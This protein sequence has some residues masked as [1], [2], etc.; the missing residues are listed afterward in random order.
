[1]LSRVP[2]IDT[3][4]FF[5]LILIITIFDPFLN[6]ELPESKINTWLK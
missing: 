6:K 2:V 3:I 1:M 4:I 5:K